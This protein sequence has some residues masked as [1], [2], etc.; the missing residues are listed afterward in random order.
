MLTKTD[1]ELK[2]MLHLCAMAA[3][4]TIRT[5]GIIQ[6][7]YK[8]KILEGKSKMSAL[9]AVRNKIVL[10]AFAVIKNNN[11]FDNKFQFSFEIS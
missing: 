8:R 11:L 4:R 6:D 2:S 1:K 3:V 7:Y 10:I 5:K 9:N